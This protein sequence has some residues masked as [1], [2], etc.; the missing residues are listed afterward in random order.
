MKLY[1]WKDIK[2]SFT[3]GIILGNGA[4]IA[5]D[6][7]F[8]YASML[9]YAER[10]RLITKNL[11]KVFK[12]LETTD[13]ELVLQMLWHAYRINEAL[14]VDDSIT[15]KAYKDLRAALI[16]SVRDFHIGYGAVS[17]R[18]LQMARFLKHFKTVASLNYDF[19]IYWAMLAGNDEFKQQWFKDCFVSGKFEED[20][21]WLRKP[22]GSADGS[23]L[24]FY[25]HGN[26]VLAAALFGDE[27]KIASD[28]SEHLFDAIVSKW[29]SGD[30][31]PLFVSEGTSEQK[32]QAINRSPYLINVYNTVLPALGS[33]VVIFGWS[34][35]DQDQ[36][37][38]KALCSNDQLK[39]LAVS[40]VASG[41]VESK[42]FRIRKT[43]RETKGDN[44]LEIAFFDAKSEGCWVSP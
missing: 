16:Q 39:G 10:N 7:R 42:C 31:S 4:S 17:D 30:Y 8:S 5:V 43:I 13:F 20:W 23:T 28:E 26:L 14:N 1:R 2:K 21:K 25:P 44:K 12:Y 24:V 37:I 9:E 11:A 6:K 36:H 38:L 40:V 18:L 29:Q 15:S 19:L 41:D 3:E 34:L 27:H 22:H 33:W 32:F 35:R